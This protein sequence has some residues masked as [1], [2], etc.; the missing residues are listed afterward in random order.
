MQYPPEAV[1]AAIKNAGMHFASRWRIAPLYLLK[2][3]EEN[4]AYPR[5]YLA[6]F[7]G[8]MLLCIIVRIIGTFASPH[9]VVQ[10][11]P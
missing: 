2:L 4:P 8:V 5:I 11:T 7:G 1:A 6:A 3:C 9:T 10:S